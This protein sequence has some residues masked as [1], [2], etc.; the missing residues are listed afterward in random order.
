MHEEPPIPVGVRVLTLL[1]FMA[2]MFS[3]SFVGAVLKPLR[4]EL[5]P[6]SEL[7]PEVFATRFS[8][9]GIWL[10]LL[11]ICWLIWA[12]FPTN[13]PSSEYHIEPRFL[14]V[15]GYAILA[16]VLALGIA[17]IISAYALRS[18]LENTYL[19]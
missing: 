7:L 17:G 5:G 10:G 6:L 2:V 15:V 9:H 1:Q 19:L 18:S 14:F 16:L 4:L 12:L 13:R 3:V 11:P 8:D